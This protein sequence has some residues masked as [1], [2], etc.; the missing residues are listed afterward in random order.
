MGLDSGC[1][2]IEVPNKGVSDFNATFVI[3]GSV[4]CISCRLDQFCLGRRKKHREYCC[5]DNRML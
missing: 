1:S 3:V 5:L 2:I 4:S